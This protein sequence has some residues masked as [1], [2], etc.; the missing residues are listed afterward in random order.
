MTAPTVSPLRGVR[1][2]RNAALNMTALVVPLLVALGTMPVLI[3]ALGTERF[4]VLAIAWMLLTYMSEL[5]LGTTTTRYAAAAVG[6]GRLDEVGVLAWTTAGLQLA[7]GLVQGALLALAAPWL[8]GSVFAMPPELAAEARDSLY[9]MAAAIPLIGLGRSFRGLLEAAH[10]F[11]LALAVHV[12]A[13]AAGYVFAAAAAVA[14]W[15][16]P[17]VFALVIVPRVLAVPAYLLAAGRALPGS[18]LRPRWDRSRVRLVAGFA[19]WAA[20]STVV[21]PLLVYLD[22]FMVGVLL[23]MTTVTYYAAAYELV[24]KLAVIPVAIAGV[25]YPAFSQMGGGGDT[26]QAERLAARSVAMI[27]VVM[28]PI[29]VLLA[30]GA[31]DGLTLWLG[32]EYARESSLAL[33][34]L[35]VGVLINAMAHVPFG[36]L[37]SW[38]RPDLPARFH[39]LELPVQ[40]A[41]TWLLVSRFGIPGAA[42]AWTARVTLDAA[43]LFAAA[44][45]LGLLRGAALAGAHVPAA[46]GIVFAGG[47]A[48]LVAAAAF[49]AVG[50]R[51]MAV[52]MLAVTTSLLL[53]AAA[54]TSGERRRIGAIVRGGAG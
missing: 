49:E 34:I 38:G 12:P 14:G 47:A 1:V 5:G 52:I 4:G 15:S 37:Q 46:L 13:T 26:A 7:V 3:G 41:L 51:V 50:G 40:L 16:L 17:A 18:S 8:V 30:G 2:A 25:L 42:L 9:L 22:R 36:L 19:G 39:L 29:L 11:D 48:A 43:L 32:A 6:A 53:W 21:S 45:R 31:A 54:M 20:V 24:G 33:R 28:G 23:T 10:R 35:T 27:V 44:S